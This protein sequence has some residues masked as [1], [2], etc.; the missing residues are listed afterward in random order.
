MS[1]QIAPAPTALVIFES[2]YGNTHVIADHVAEGLR[3]VFA[4]DVVSAATTTAERMAGVDLIVVGA[5][6]HVHGLPGRRSREAAVAALERSPDDLVLETDALGP[7][8]RELFDQLGG[9]SHSAAAAFDTRIDGPAIFTGRASRG[10]ARRLRDHGFDLVTAPESFLVD[11]HNHLLEGEADRA[12][13][14]GRAVAARVAGRETQP[15][16]R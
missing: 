16:V 6:T 8:L 11:K 9:E 13:S 7:G 2:M 5:P 14:W 12:T 10:I 1:G 15:Q 4:T 3:G